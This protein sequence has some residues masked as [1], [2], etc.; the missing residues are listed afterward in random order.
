MPDRPYK[1]CNERLA[2]LFGFTLEEC[3]ATQPFLE[4]FVAE[5]DRKMFSWNYHKAGSPLWPSR[6]P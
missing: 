2:S 3:C 6:S 1:T 4:N 5:E